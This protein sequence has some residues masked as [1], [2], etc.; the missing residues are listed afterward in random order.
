[1]SSIAKKARK[2]YKLKGVKPGKIGT[3]DRD[4]RFRSPDGQEWASRFEWLVYDAY[5][6]AGYA[7][8]R[9]I[10]GSSDTLSYNESVRGATCDSCGKAEISKPRTYTPDLFFAERGAGVEAGSYIEAKGYLRSP[11]RALLRAFCKTRKDVAL[12]II[13]QRDFPVSK[14]ST[15]SSWTNRYLKVP[16]AIW[17]GKPPTEWKT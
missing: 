15:I 16:Y 5:Q 4:M 8:R 9:T 6:R 13:Y 1:M 14:S 17:N 7:C 11:Q 10:K 2:Y 12:R 3:K